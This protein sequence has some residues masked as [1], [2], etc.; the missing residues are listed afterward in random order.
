MENDARAADQG[1]FDR[2]AAVEREARRLGVTLTGILEAVRRGWFPE[3][4]R[5][6]RGSFNNPFLDEDAAKLIG[7]AIFGSLDEQEK[8]VIN[9][10]AEKGNINVS[11]ANRVL[12]KDWRTAKNILDRLVKKN[13]LERRSTGKMRDPQA[14]YVLKR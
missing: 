4:N 8:V 10:I 2:L 14:R 7:E 6:L 5:W 1:C 11:D 3:H 12:H 9:F 13:V